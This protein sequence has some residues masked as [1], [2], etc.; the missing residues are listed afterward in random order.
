MAKSF[1]LGSMAKEYVLAGKVGVILGK[2]GPGMVFWTGTVVGL[3]GGGECWGRRLWQLLP[4]GGCCFFF[5]FF[6]FLV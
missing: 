1:F 5:F 6:F 4:F 3:W 2:R